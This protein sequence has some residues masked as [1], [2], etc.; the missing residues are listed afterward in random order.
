[1]RRLA[2]FHLLPVLMLW[3]GVLSVPRHARAQEYVWPTNASQWLTSTFGESRPRRFHTGFDIKTWNQVGYQAIAVRDGSVIRMQM[4]PFGYGRAL[5]VKLDTGETAV[6]A[7]LLKFAD[8]LQA[9]AEEEQERRGRYSITRQFP[10]GALPV[11]KGEVIAYTGQSGIGS[12]HLHFELRNARNEPINP[13][14]MGFRLQDDISPTI[15]ALAVTPLGPGSTVN[16]DFRPQILQPASSRRHAGAMFS[17]IPQPIAFSGRVGLAVSAFDLAAGVNNRLAVYSLKLFVDEQLQFHSRYDQLDFRHNRYIELDRDYGLERNGYGQFYKLYKEPANELALY[18]HLNSFGGALQVAALRGA[19]NLDPVSTSGAEQGTRPLS[20][21]NQ[22]GDYNRAA[23]ATAP[24]ADYRDTASGRAA[25]GLS[26]GKHSFRVEVSDYFGNVSILTGQLLAGPT[27]SIEPILLSADEQELVV[28]QLVS[29]QGREIRDVEVHAMRQS[30]SSLPRH[31]GGEEMKPGAQRTRPAQIGWRKIPAVLQAIFHPAATIP[32]ADFPVPQLRI[33][34][35]DADLI[36][37]LAIDADSLRS[38]PCFIPISFYRG[39]VLPLRLQ[40]R[41]EFYRE[42]VRL[43][44][45]ASQ[46]L[47]APPNLTLTCS[48]RADL[49]AAGE[50]SLPARGG[51]GDRP[52][53]Q[54]GRKEQS[55]GTVVISAPGEGKAAP[56]LR[57]RLL[58]VEPHLYVA[59]VPLATLTTE[60]SAE[61]SVIVHASAEDLSGQR[62]AARDSFAITAIPGDGAG[63]LAAADG[64]MEVKF[65]RGSLYGALYGRAEDDIAVRS[66]PLRASPVYRVSPRDIPLADGANVVFSLAD[67]VTRAEQLGVYYRETKKWVFIDNR[68]DLENRTISARVFSLED[69]AVYRDN[70]PPELTGFE[71]GNGATVRLPAAGRPTISVTVRDTMSGFASEESIVLSLD[72]RKVIAEYDPERDLVLYT[73]KHLLLRGRHEYTISAVD[74]CG[75]VAEKSVSFIVL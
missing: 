68:L 60:H 17:E 74:R 15:M 75:N 46:P 26:W 27:F 51:R 44:I 33:N 38:L 47:A 62:A 18:G 1:M 32:F 7:H 45:E 39:P 52:K 61:V 65:W 72:G 20:R 35:A 66:E 2:P 56:T 71:P 48:G 49:A 5:Y 36:R 42:Y 57:P 54:A 41:T 13:L 25:T 19:G 50:S 23:D 37:L 34:T 9:I 10:P 30:L 67:T 70:L 43:E 73:P 6:Y 40:V 28:K 55:G 24:L 11:K 58:P 16:S 64:K 29:P 22:A 69:F 53:S 4:S 3:A 63:R 12:P 14:R 21:E 31:F 59:Q 8:R